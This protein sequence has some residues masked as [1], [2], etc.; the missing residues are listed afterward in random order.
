MRDHVSHT[1]SL[2]NFQRSLITYNLQLLQGAI[3]I[4]SDHLLPT[5]YNLQP[6]RHYNQR[7]CAYYFYKFQIKHQIF[8]GQRMI[9]V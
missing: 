1:M 4:F 9:G 6:L 5:T 7:L 8:A 3:T 2:Y